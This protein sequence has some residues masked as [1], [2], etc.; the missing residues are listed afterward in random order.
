MSFMKASMLRLNEKATRCWFSYF[1][2]TR[3]C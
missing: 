2:I 3:K 1:Q